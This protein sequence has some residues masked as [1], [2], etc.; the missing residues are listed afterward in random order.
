MCSPAAHGRVLFATALLLLVGSARA[1]EMRRIPDAGAPDS[2][3]ILSPL[4]ERPAARSLPTSRPIGGGPDESQVI[5]D[6]L[7]PAVWSGGSMFVLGG[8]A[9]VWRRLRRGLR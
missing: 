3:L 7:P 9:A 6:P 8:A 1:A 4:D 5:R 2:S